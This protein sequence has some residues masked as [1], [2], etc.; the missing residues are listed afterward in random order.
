MLL[1][2]GGLRPFF[3]A[4]VAYRTIRD[5]WMW[6][7]DIVAAGEL[8]PVVKQH[9]TVADAAVIGVPDPEPSSTDTPLP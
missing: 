1:Y 6:T 7:G 5:G 3:S 4:S 9:P 2:M 8:E